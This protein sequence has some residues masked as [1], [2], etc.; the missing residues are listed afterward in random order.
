MKYGKIPLVIGLIGHR[1]I[2]PEELKRV[3]E[4]FDDSIGGLLSKYRNTEV[5]VLTSLADGADRLAHSSRH[6]DRMKIVGVL[7]FTLD[8]YR[9][10]FESTDSI[11]AFESILSKCDQIVIRGSQ[12]SSSEL[13]RSEIRAKAYGETAEWLVGNSKILYAVW[14]G[15]FTG[16]VG[17]TGETIRKS[18]STLPNGCFIHIPASNAGSHVDN[19]CSCN[20]HASS[21]QISDPLIERKDLFNKFIQGSAPT[22]FEV[23]DRS[24]TQLRQTYDRRVK[25]SLFFGLILLNLISVEQGTKDTF[26]ILLVALM[27][28]ITAVYWLSLKRSRIKEVYED[29]RVIAESIRVESWLKSAGVRSN[30]FEAMGVKELVDPWLMEML[31]DLDEWDEITL[32]S[33]ESRTESP[34]D[35]PAVTLW[36]D[37]QIDY[38]DGTK[39]RQGAVGR[40]LRKADRYDFFAKVSIFSGLTIYAFSKALDFLWG[41]ELNVAYEEGFGFVF[42][43][44]LSM[45]AFSLAFSQLMGYKEI[46]ARYSA[47]LRVLKNG[48]IQLKDSL[49]SGDR[50]NA[51]SIVKEIGLES[52]QETLYWF[53]VRKTRDVRPL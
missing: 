50:D 4:E 8:E 10:D 15:N 20:G 30:A 9:K 46:A 52:L 51:Q 14:D 37:D 45:S 27:S 41:D 18:I 23:F 48:A 32:G 40:N 11:N 7:P 36:L 1:N 17:G 16:K 47:S 43:L 31:K 29:L 49:D 35:W 28:A 44:A 19:S 26:W 42:S 33:S 24:A 34:T 53:T 3:Q 38:L 2:E 21:G 12:Y 22:I 5:L 13:A 6:R 39:D 25:R